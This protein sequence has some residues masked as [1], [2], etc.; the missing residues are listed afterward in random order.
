MNVSNV[1]GVS[2][3]QTDPRRWKKGIYCDESV[4]AVIVLRR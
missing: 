4:L 3:D 2:I 1:D